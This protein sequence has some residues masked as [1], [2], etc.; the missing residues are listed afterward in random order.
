MDN[1]EEY[2]SKLRQTLID[3]EALDSDVMLP[4]GVKPNLEILEWCSDESRAVAIES[5]ASEVLRKAD[6]LNSYAD[7]IRESLG[8]AEKARNDYRVAKGFESGMWM[9]CVSADEIWSY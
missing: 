2:L 5:L 4:E 3:L 1:R 6:Q 9:P 8:E 7:L